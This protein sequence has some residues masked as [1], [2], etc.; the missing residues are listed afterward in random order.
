MRGHNPVNRRVPL[1]YVAPSFSNVSADLRENTVIEITV[2]L[3]QTT[4]YGKES[5]VASK[6]SRFLGSFK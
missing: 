1:V 2:K 3:F 6:K 4:V 5:V